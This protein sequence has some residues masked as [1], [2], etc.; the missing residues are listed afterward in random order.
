MQN[1]EMSVNGDILTV[2]IDLS[3]RLGPSTSG[4][5][6]IVGTTSGNAKIPGHESLRIGV[7]CFEK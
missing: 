6:T 3:K 1:I 5:T 7:N 2:K 4:K